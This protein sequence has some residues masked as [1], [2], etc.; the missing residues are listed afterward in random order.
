MCCIANHVHTMIGKNNWLLEIVATSPLCI[1]HGPSHPPFLLSPT[2]FV[3]RFLNHFPISFYWEV[4]QISPL[5]FALLNVNSIICFDLSAWGFRAQIVYCKSQIPSKEVEF[6]YQ[7]C[8]HSLC[9]HWLRVKGLGYTGF[10][11]GSK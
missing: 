8:F 11:S 7:A 3:W 10:V 5:A 1:C 4:L 2:T 6:H 9:G